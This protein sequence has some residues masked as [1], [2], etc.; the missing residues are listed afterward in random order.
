MNPGRIQ[1]RRYESQIR[2]L[3]DNLDHLPDP[4]KFSELSYWRDRDLQVLVLKPEDEPD[5]TKYVATRDRATAKGLHIYP[6]FRT[7]PLSKEASPRFQFG[8]YI[9]REFWQKNADRLTNVAALRLPGDP[10][11]G[12]DMESY[13]G[14][15]E[16]T[17]SA[18]TTKQLT[19]AQL[20]AAM[21]P[22]IDALRATNASVALYPAGTTKDGEVWL[23]GEDL[24]YVAESV[25]RE[26][27]E[28][29]TEATF[30]NSEQYRRSSKR[31]W[32]V[33][34]ATF[35]RLMGLLQSRFPGCV[36]RP[37]I[38]DLER[39]WTKPYRSDLCRSGAYA[40]W[41]FDW[42]RYDAADFGKPAYRSGI[43]L[44]KLNG[45][46]HV[47]PMQPMRTSVPAE[48][49]TGKSPDGP[50]ELAQWGSTNTTDQALLP[51]AIPHFEGIQFTAPPP[52]EPGKRPLWAWAGLGGQSV[53]PK[54][55][56]APFTVDGTLRLPIDIPDSCPLFGGVWYNLSSWQVVYDA[57]RDVIALCVRNPFPKPN[58]S[59][60]YTLD[61]M[62]VPRRGVD[63]RFHVGRHKLKWL[64]KVTELPEG[65][66]NGTRTDLPAAAGGDCTNLLIGAGQI[67][68][69]FPRSNSMAYCPGILLVKTWSIYDWL[70]E[71][72]ELDAL[73]TDTWV[74]PDHDHTIF[75]REGSWPYG[76][77]RGNL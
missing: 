13:D 20:R 38:F 42:S 67:V 69:D 77:G 51:T 33:V 2:T 57:D 26:R 31:G 8:S 59:R 16:P 54:D 3:F 45:A 9:E 62:A 7:Q 52:P 53:L 24:L 50:V 73:R 36:F 4:E 21:Q 19:V 61:M 63:L 58:E 25:G 1:I 60:R 55:L 41:G 72:A 6:A 74:R 44:S 64:Y 11:I 15:S 32:P 23:P 66:V 14:G 34:A 27:M 28:L 40:P 37:G 49:D 56:S 46:T 35:L 48:F 68:A 12:L 10:W 43:T 71:D 29:W 65:T 39:V 76:Y 70:L 5:R 75:S 17:A 47:W 18:L 30:E 22:F